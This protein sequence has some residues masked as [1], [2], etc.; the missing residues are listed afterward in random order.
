MRAVVQRV[1]LARVRVAGETISEIRRGL[2]VLLAVSTTDTPANALLLARKTAALRIFEDESGKM[3]LTAA[4]VG[5]EVLCVSQ[6][7]LFGD[8]RRGNRP[9]FEGSAPGPVAEPLYQAF[10]SAIEQAGLKC[11]KGLF[12]A[13]MEVEVL[14]DGP[15]TLIIDTEDLAQPRRA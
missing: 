6:F 13:E 8:V 10:C 7:T 3:N 1:S 5:G 11:E 4:A 12:G 14:N 9:S 15:V 2:F